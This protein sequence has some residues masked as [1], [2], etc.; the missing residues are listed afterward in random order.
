[1]QNTKNFRVIR[2]SE[3]MNGLAQAYVRIVA[4]IDLFVAL[5]ACHM[6]F[7]KFMCERSCRKRN[8]NAHKNQTVSVCCDLKRNVFVF[9]LSWYLKYKLN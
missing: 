8:N 9:F 4:Y 6:C 3:C 7:F 1:M 5:S 2:R